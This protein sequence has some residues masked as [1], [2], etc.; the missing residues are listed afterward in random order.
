MT[1]GRVAN[2]AG[3]GGRMRRKYRPAL[4]TVLV[5]FNLTVLLLPFAGL[6]FFRIAESHLVRETE[7]ELIGKGAIIAAMFKAR[8]RASGE[9]LESL[10]SPAAEEPGPKVDD[11]YHPIPPVT[12]LGHDEILPPRPDARLPDKPPE[13]MA[14]RV[15]EELTSVLIEA[16]RATLIGTR[17]LDHQGI[18]VA[19]SAPVTSQ[20]LI[21]TTDV[22]SAPVTGTA[23]ASS[24]FGLSFAHVPEVTRALTGRYAAVLRQRVSS[25]PQPALTSISRGGRVRVFAVYP[26]VEGGRLL[27]L[28]YL[29]RTPDNLMH[30]LYFWR[31][32]VA[33]AALL[34]IALALLLAALASRLISR[35]IA[36][37]RLRA[38]QLAAGAPLST[39][40]LDHAGTREL[41][42]LSDSF[43][44]MARALQHRA[45]YV[46]DFAAHVSHELKTPL[47][48]IQGAVELLGEHAST[49]SEGERAHFLCNVAEDTQR[50]RRL[51]ER[52]HELAR[53]E[54]AAAVIE[55]IDLGE[56]LAEIGEAHATASQRI[57]LEAVR[58]CL[59]RLSRE[60]L[61][62]VAANLIANAVQS[63]AAR[64]AIRLI[65]EADAAMIAFSDDGRGIPDEIAER[66]F[67][68][69]FST[70][71][72]SGGTGLGLQIVR[73]IIESSGGTIVHA[74][75]ASG[76]TF[77]IRLPLARGQ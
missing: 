54:H 31:D 45:T 65:I 21:V 38:R 75:S 3:A 35:P 18:V 68:P 62:I 19:T 34:T 12:D 43:S 49:M 61:G 58:G 60:S 13:P 53:A 42:D 71:Q 39:A 2:S 63:G 36:A 6:V 28:V 66:I 74:P 20:P 69:F 33:L 16:Q 1:L 56:A 25:K 52:L 32:R 76:A 9:R 4:S 37:L 27:G 44:D 47:T 5:L 7:N 67:D 30:K 59:V 73:S 51:V 14:L 50:L 40:T 10:G 24:D 70:R 17:L 29:S 11:H 41:A 23:P 15:G 55:T 46:R 72:T 26:I 77:R 8:A 57:D 22:A 64:L 48:A